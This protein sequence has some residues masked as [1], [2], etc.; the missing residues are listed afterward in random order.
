MPWV[1]TA[2]PET[3]A[4]PV[5]AAWAACS[6]AALLERLQLVVQRPVGGARSRAPG[7]LGQ[8][9]VQERRLERG[10]LVAA[11]EDLVGERA[12]A[13]LERGQRASLARH[14]GARRAR[15]GDDVRVLVRR[16]GT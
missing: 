16:R 6:A 11:R 3:F 10:D 2:I 15:P 13:R 12:V 9:L 14:R 5:A 4:L 8:L 1:S 7:E